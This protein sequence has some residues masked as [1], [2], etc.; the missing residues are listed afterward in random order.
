M[1]VYDNLGV[2]VGRYA[3][4]D[5]SALA[6]LLFRQL[7]LGRIYYDMLLLEPSAS[8]DFLAAELEFFVEARVQGAL[9]STASDA[10]R[11]I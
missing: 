5:R 4:D 2:L 11:L 8:A 3:L 9:R 1:I 10:A 7:V 6:A